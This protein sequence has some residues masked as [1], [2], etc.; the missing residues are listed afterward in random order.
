MSLTFPDPYDPNDTKQID[1][2]VDLIP[3][4]SG[5]ISTWEIR[6]KWATESDW[7]KGYQAAT[8]LQEQLGT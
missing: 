4:L 3:L 8:L 2:P 5:L 7:Q 6:R 1:V